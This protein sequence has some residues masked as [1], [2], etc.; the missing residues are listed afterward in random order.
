MI[1]QCNE[2]DNTIIG[3]E[4]ECV[5]LFLG[6]SANVLGFEDKLENVISEMVDRLISLNKNNLFTSSSSAT[7]SVFSSVVVD[8]EVIGSRVA[9]QYFADPRFKYSFFHLT[10]VDIQIGQDDVNSL[11]VS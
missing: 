7:V 5:E 4:N 6:M 8:E 2:D 11:F 10:T 9:G 3:C 1:A